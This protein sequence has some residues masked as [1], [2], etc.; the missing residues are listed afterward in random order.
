MRYC[1]LFIGLLDLEVTI[2][3]FI[4]FYVFSAGLKPF[5]WKKKRTKFKLD[6]RIVQLLLYTETTHTHS[7]QIH[8]KHSPIQWLRFTVICNILW[9]VVFTC[10]FPFYMCVQHGLPLNSSGFFALYPL[11][12]WYQPAC[13]CFFLHALTFNT[14]QQ[15]NMEEIVQQNF[16]Q[17]QI[18]I[19]T[20]KEKNKK[21]RMLH[22]HRP[23]R[24][25]QL[26]NR[27]ETIRKIKAKRTTYTQAHSLTFAKKEKRIK[28]NSWRKTIALA[29]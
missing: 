11:V 16:P 7:T 9:P 19:Q 2:S 4:Q 22:A 26:L 17:F 21:K 5:E 3:I 14:Q 24:K 13:L 10:F 8:K 23:I 15:Q 18:I 28:A 29:S 6:W 25:S 20:W 1:K 12:M 27:R